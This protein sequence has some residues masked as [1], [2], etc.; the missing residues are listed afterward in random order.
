MTTQINI[1][2][3][4]GAQ[5]VTADDKDRAEAAALVVLG[6]VTPETAYAAYLDYFEE[7]DGVQPATG[8][9]A[10]WEKAQAAA[11]IALTEGWYNPAGATCYISA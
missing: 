9:A 2:I 4:H 7:T 11:D 6:N 3:S 10:L 5:Y 8:L 1:E